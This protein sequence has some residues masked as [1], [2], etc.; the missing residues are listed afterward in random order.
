V[1]LNALSMVID[2][3]KNSWNTNY[4][5]ESDTHGFALLSRPN[6]AETMGA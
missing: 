5:Y 2:E 4:K 3:H 1:G 6:L